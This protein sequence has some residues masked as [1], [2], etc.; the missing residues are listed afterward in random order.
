MKPSN[1]TMLHFYQQL[2]QV[3]Y[4][5]AAVDGVVREE[6]IERLNDIVKKYWLNLEDTF[7]EFNTDSAYQIEIVFAWL[8]NNDWN[9]EN[10]LGKFKDFKE[11]HPS[12][13]GYKNRLL[14]QGTAQAIAKSFYGENKA[15]GIFLKKLKAIL[16]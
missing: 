5:A 1:E 16:S 13:F 14:V 4:G 2:G 8:N 12:L 10:I 15:E 3:F 6:E 11:E 9:K 7:D